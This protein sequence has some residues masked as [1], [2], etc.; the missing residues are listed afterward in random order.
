[1]ARIAGVNIPDNRHIWVSLTRIFGIGK[2]TALRICHQNQIKP[3]RL[4]SDLS[5]QEL[6]VVRQYISSNVQ[7]E[8]DLR[9]EIKMNIKRLMEIKSYRG[10][11]HR[12]SL[13]LRGQ[14]TKTNAQTAKKRRRK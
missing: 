10:V 1:M 12:K 2:T 14:K 11:R 4:V 13:P 8:G 9:R 3:S 7:H 6:E 5:E